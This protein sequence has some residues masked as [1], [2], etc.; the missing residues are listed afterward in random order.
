[1]RRALDLLYALSGGLGALFLALILVTVLAQVALN[2]A[3]GVSEALTGQAM[4]LL[5][6]S[7]A[8]FAGYFLAA[9]T[10]FALAYTFNAGGHIRVTLVL[11]RL[12][13]RLRQGAEIFC[14][15]LAALTAGYFAWY[16]ASLTHE[17]WRF[18]DL[19]PG[20]VAIPTWIPQAAM[21]AGLAMLAIAG[22]DAFGQAAGGAMPA[23]DRE[24]DR[25][26]T[27]ME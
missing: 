13:A 27:G 18:G 26:D 17:S 10:F 6:P 20:L 19:S 11:Q 1:M 24:Q 12:P 9:G 14:S 5:I 8:D 4:G 21:T 23:Y 16:A 3:D 2:M 25:L 15:G 22:L 7:Y